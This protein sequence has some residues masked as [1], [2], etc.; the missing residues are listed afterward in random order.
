MSLS[1]ADLIRRL[2][3]SMLMP[4]STAEAT[5]L[6]TQA[7]ELGLGGVVIPTNLI[8]LARQLLR[9]RE[10]KVVAA[11]NFPCG[12]MTQPEVLF[13]VTHAESLG[14][15]ELLLAVS[16]TAM[17]DGRLDDVRGMLRQVRKLSRFPQVTMGFEHPLLKEPG[18]FT[19]FLEALKA[20]GVTSVLPNLGL[21]PHKTVEADVI[22]SQKHI[23]GV[24]V[25]AN[26]GSSSP[27]WMARNLCEVGASRVLAQHAIKLAG[28]LRP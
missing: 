1:E 25:T 4:L 18:A 10:T 3:Q 23:P 22:Q 24:D 17:L 13:C 9:G 2:F 7:G 14:A 6:L 16:T 15:H 8:T 28:E 11:V 19:E 20:E 5:A 12:A 21:T 27:A 26:L